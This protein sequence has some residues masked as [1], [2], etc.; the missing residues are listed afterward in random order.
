MRGVYE[1]KPLPPVERFWRHV[2]PEPNTG[3]WLWVG[4]LTGGGYGALGV[5]GAHEGLVRAH[6]FAFMEF[7]GSIP[8][9]LELDHLCRVRRC[10]N[11]WHLEAVT[12][13]Q[14]FLRGEHPTA[15]NV[16]RG[17]CPQGHSMADAYVSRGAR[18]CRTCARN[19]YDPERRRARYLAAIGR[20]S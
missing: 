9:G 17:Q 16:R 12:R 3:C 4:G 15:V 18:S 5:G 1:R 8:A 10:V 7:R 20:P 14:N 6:R 19:K 11:P 13:S 2:E